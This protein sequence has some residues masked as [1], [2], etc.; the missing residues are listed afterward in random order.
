[1]VF[2]GSGSVSNDADASVGFSAGFGFG[3]GFSVPTPAPVS[4]FVGAGNGGPGRGAVS[5]S[6]FPFV[7]LHEND[8]VSLGPK[9]HTMAM[10]TPA[11]MANFFQAKRLLPMRLGPIP[12]SRRS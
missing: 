1:M 6:S 3:G 12:P 8:R 4:A 5:T 7:G 10:S 11:A 2:V 9:N